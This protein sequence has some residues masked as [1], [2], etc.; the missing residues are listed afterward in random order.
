M[1]FVEDIHHQYAGLDPAELMPPLRPFIGNQWSA[2]ASHL[3]IA[4]CGIN[5]YYREKDWVHADGTP[6][7]PD[8]GAY[9]RWFGYNKRLFFQQS[10]TQASILA[11][12]LLTQEAF[13][14]LTWDGDKSL[15]VTNM[16][17]RYL[18]E[19]LGDKAHKLADESGQALLAE[20]R[21]TWRQELAVMAAH[22]R[23]PHAVIV[24]GHRIWR[25]AWTAFAPKHNPSAWSLHYE[26]MPKG[27]ELHHHL[28]I[29][30]VS[31]AGQRRP[32]VLTRLNHPAS[33][34]HEK[35]AKWLVEHPEFPS[36]IQPHR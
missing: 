2:D 6:K 7:P 16:V 26:P 5:S 18:P 14:H 17:K 22:D 32:L 27:T 4:V 30:T 19:S 21:Q 12:A 3:R 23:L 9:A 34:N 29:V 10:R 36:R 33:P 28:N 15:Y 8:A 11:E 13:E 1:S 35:R 31:E 24:F 25:G 20:G